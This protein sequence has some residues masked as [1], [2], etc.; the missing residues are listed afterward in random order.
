MR[1]FVQPAT[2]A[3]PAAV[4]PSEGSAAELSPVKNV[5]VWIPFGSFSVSCE[6]RDTFGFGA[7]D[8]AKTLGTGS[9]RAS[10]ASLQLTEYR[11]ARQNPTVKPSNT[12]HW[13]HPVAEAQSA[14]RTQSRHDGR[15]AIRGDSGSPVANSALRGPVETLTMESTRTKAYVLSL[16]SVACKVCDLLLY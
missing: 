16:R 8:S 1:G 6:F 15:A 7:F 9:G 3:D 5:G 12:D 10:A 4:P 14:V 11:E 2:H 13:I